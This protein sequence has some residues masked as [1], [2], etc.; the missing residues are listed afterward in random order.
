MFC[1]KYFIHY[2]FLE[3]VEFPLRVPTRRAFTDIGVSQPFQSISP[4]SLSD[5]QVL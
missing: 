1:L 2:T 3:A 5:I 4:R